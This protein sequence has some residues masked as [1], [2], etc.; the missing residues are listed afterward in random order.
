MP[1]PPHR[2]GSTP[3]ELLVLKKVTFDNLENHNARSEEEVAC[4]LDDDNEKAY[5]KI[6]RYL[7]EQGVKMRMSW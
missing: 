1:M 3:P 4:F 7:H 2:V 6:K 5:A